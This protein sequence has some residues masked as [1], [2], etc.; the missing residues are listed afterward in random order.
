MKVFISWSGDRS[1]EAAKAL[2]EWLR[3]IIHNLEPWMSKLDINA[4]ARWS[5]EIAEQLEATKFGI[6]CLTSD[7]LSKPWIMF[8]AGA[9]AKTID[10]DTHVC[11]Y[12]IGLEPTSIP[13]GPLTQFQAKKANKE[14]TLELVMAI[15]NV[16]G[17]KAL[18]D[19]RL[20]RT[21]ERWW[22]ELE[23]KLNNLPA[24]ETVVERR[25]TQDMV[26]EILE[27]V[28]DFSRVQSEDYRALARVVLLI[29]E[30]LTAPE[31]GSANALRGLARPGTSPATAQG[32]KGNLDKNVLAALLGGT[33][34]DTP[35]DG[36]EN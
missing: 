14:E 29:G 11:P 5:N 28:R 31:Q 22:P 36:E 4:G 18:D 17:E 6:I 16:L 15:N 27:L 3:D 30:K 20:K 26:E 35:E 25:E 21:F 23:E 10:K 34:K 12:L 32:L 2:H 8:E 24:E 1:K 19:D 7:N 33:N 13:A 9:L